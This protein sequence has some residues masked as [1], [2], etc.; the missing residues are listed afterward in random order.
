MHRSVSLRTTL[1]ALLIIL[2]YAHAFVHPSWQH[3]H[4]IVAARGS[5]RATAPTLTEFFSSADFDAKPMTNTD[6]EEWLQENDPERKDREMEAARKAE[7][8]EAAAKLTTEADNDAAPDIESAEFQQQVQG[9]DTS[10]GG[11]EPWGSWSQDDR[12]VFLEIVLPEDTGGARLT[13]DATVEGLD[14]CADTGKQIIA[15]TWAQR[16]EPSELMWTVDTSSD[17]QRV[18]CVEVPKRKRAGTERGAI[19][20]SL[21]VCDEAVEADGLVGLRRVYHSPSGEV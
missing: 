4:A 13:V 3:A 6:L 10:R 15:A 9:S 1:C 12:L 11:V 7:M 17:G 8:M 19:F 20:E 2:A 18:L 21:R 16:M 14:A 5:R